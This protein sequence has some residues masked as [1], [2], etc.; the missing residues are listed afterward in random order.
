MKVKKL[1][2]YMIIVFFGVSSAW[3]K[4]ASLNDIK[5]AH[6]YN[7]S[8]FTQWPETKNK[9]EVFNICV[10]KKSE[11]K[12]NIKKLAA[13]KLNGL[14]IKVNE[15]K[16]AN[17]ISQCHLLVLT[18]LK[19]DDLDTYVLASVEENIL[20]V[21]ATPGHAS[22]GVMFNLYV[23]GKKVKFEANVEMINKTDLKVSSNVLR[24]ANIIK[25]TGE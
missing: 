23:Y 20:T 2:L 4:S 9:N 25:S 19:K 6:I 14:P 18:D 21:S 12:E 16:D 8:R 24:L 1:F 11:L 13:V 15:V 5:A 7:F 17:E 3:A 22:F 10:H